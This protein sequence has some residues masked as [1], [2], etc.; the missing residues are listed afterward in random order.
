MI[1]LILTSLALKGRAGS[2]EGWSTSITRSHDFPFFFPPESRD[3]TE[4]GAVHSECKRNSFWQCLWRH[5]F[6]F[7]VVIYI[8]K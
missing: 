3:E 7:V 1:S 2:A 5:L 4:V 8:P 6:D